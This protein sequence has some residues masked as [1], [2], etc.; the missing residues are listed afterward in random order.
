MDAGNT[1]PY[2]TNYLATLS[3]NKLNNAGF[4]EI[5]SELVQNHAFNEISGELID[6]TSG[7]ANS[8]PSFWEV[9]TPNSIDWI[10]GCSSSVGFYST[11]F[12]VET[13]KAYRI[14]LTIEGYS[15]TG[16]IGVSTAGGVPISVRLSGNGTVTTTFVATGNNVIN[17]FGRNTNVGTF[18][19]ISL[20]K[21]DPDGDWTLESGWELRFGDARRS[22]VSSNSGIGQT[23]N[24]SS[25]KTYKIGYDRTYESGTSG[26]T[27]IFGAFVEP[28]VAVQ[29]GIES[30]TSPD[31]VTVTDH[32]IPQY[33]GSTGS[34]R[35]F[36][37]GDWTGTFDNCTLKEMD[38]N[39]YWGN[40]SAFFDVFIKEGFAEFIN[41]APG[42]K[43]QQNFGVVTGQQYQI[44]FEIFNY[45]SGGVNVYLGGGYANGSTITANGTYTFYRT[46]A[47]GNNEFFF[48]A[49]SGTNANFKIRN[50]TVKEFDPG[51][52]Y[53]TIRNNAIAQL[54]NNKEYKVVIDFGS[55]TTVG[56]SLSFFSMGEPFADRTVIPAGTTGVL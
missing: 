15:G 32:F 41:A 22:G 25:G 24:V 38:P 33:D 6:L 2:L 44:S 23:F 40:P 52:M 34:M 9:L 8:C 49:M 17:I 30:S 18:S 31:T 46:A 54:Q 56:N 11:G 35:W 20:K 10:T 26:T 36:G 55:F 48:E 43:L 28:G 19:N 14:S 5:G 47:S 21:L 37:I 29:R 51:T 7:S 13:G 50:I 4:T 3:S 45:S 42:N 27:N 1:L 12:T 53:R 16:N 39:N